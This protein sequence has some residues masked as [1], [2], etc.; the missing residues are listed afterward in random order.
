MLS[1]Y[2]ERFTRLC[3]AA[4][5]DPYGGQVQQSMTEMPF[6]AALADA[7]GEEGEH[8]G[9]PFVRVTP[10]LL[11]DPDTP[12][13]LGDLIRRERDGARYRVCSQPSDR[14]TPIQAGFPFCEIRL[15]RMEA[16]A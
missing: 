1:D 7:L 5:P 12:L 13:A 9:K 8:A 2:F 4:L 3:A 6:S 16:D 10:Y 15:E 11:C 14:R